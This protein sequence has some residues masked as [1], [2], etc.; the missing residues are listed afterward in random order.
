MSPEP[1]NRSEKRRIHRKSRAGCIICKQRRVKCDEVRPRCGKCTI[2]NRPCSYGGETPASSLGTPPSFS[3]PLLVDSEGQRRFTLLEMALMYHASTNL[4]SYMALGYNTY[5]IIRT[6]LESADT[7]PY[8][9]DQLL[10]LSALHLSVTTSDVSG[11]YRQQAT[12]LQNRALR[13][14]QDTQDHALDINHK[15][16]FLFSAFLGIQVLHNTLA[17]HNNSL[18]SFIVAFVDYTHIHRGVRT[19]I[20]GH[21]QSILGSDLKDL[22]P[23]DTWPAVGSFTPGL[24]TAQLRACLESAPNI[25]DSTLTASLESLNWLQYVLD[26]ARES[27][28]KERAGVHMLVSWP[29]IVPEA[30]VDALYQHRPEALVVLAFF[31]AILHQYRDFWIF[32]ESGMRIFGIIADHVGPY[33]SEALAWP[34]QVMAKAKA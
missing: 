26:I 17:E 8:F 22:L 32:G 6:A 34:R 24:E 18:G 16:C 28:V 33:W 13:L 14:F 1:Q 20:H 30:Y 7:A 31:A 5:P 29:V 10:A 27:P 9:L 15:P 12:K 2:G 25:C 11:T 3:A 21:W 19:V 4:T 23:I